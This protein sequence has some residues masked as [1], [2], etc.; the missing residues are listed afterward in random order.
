MSKTLDQAI[1]KNGEDY[2][3]V[4]ENIRDIYLSEGTLL[5]LLD[6]ERVLDEI[7]L[8]SFRNW[9]K[10]ELV[11]GPVYEKYHV[12][13][14]FMWPKP[15]M[16]DPRGAE[17][18]LDYGCEITYQLTQLKTTKKIESPDDFRPGTKFGKNVEK[19]IWLV[20]IVM[21]KKLI[22]DINQGSLELENDTVDLEDVDQAYETGADDDVNR[23]PDAQG[24]PSGVTG[25]AV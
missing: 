21:P 22:S 25:A 23:T 24:G 15:L 20:E 14:K 5:T 4:A 16:P 10:G 8:Y 9:K 13:C 7:D 11:E 3:Q 2:W 19:P 18:L 6:F 17:R 1:F 12:R